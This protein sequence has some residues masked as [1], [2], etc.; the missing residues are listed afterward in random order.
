[1][2]HDQGVITDASTNAAR[3]TYTSNAEGRL[4][5]DIE[6]KIMMLGVNKHP[7]VTL[8]TQ[9]GKDYDGKAFK[10]SGILKRTATQPEFKWLEKLPGGR[11]CKV[12][13]SYSASGQI[14]ISVSGAG[15]SSAY[16]FTAGDMV[17]NFRTGERMLVDSVQSATTVRIGTNGRAYGSTVAAA[18]AANDSLFII[19]NVN[20]ENGGVRNVNSTRT[21]TESNYTLR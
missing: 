8:L 15:S 6:D 13:A 20:E 21:E 4:K 17:W 11:F 18:G 5:I 14:D 1:L 16:I 9:V 10:G 3:S 7:L 19:G 12:S 2:T